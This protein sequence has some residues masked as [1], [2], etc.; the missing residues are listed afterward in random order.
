MLSSPFPLWA[1]CWPV[2]HYTYCNETLHYLYKHGQQLLELN[3]WHTYTDTVIENL[4]YK[5]WIAIMYFYLRL[6]QVIMGNY[7]TVIWTLDW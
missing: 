5:V 2:K 4:S 3:N 6:N 7:A 1:S